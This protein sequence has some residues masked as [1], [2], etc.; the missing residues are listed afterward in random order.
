MS[1]VILAEKPNQAQNYAAAF[2]KQTTKKGYIEV[3]DSTLFQG[4]VYITWGFGHLVQLQEP[5]KYKEEWGKWSLDSLP[6]LPDRYIFEVDP[7]KRVQFNIVKGLLKEASLI[8]VGTDSDREGQNIAMSIIELAGAANKPIKRLW[9]NSLETDEII[10]G[11]KNLRNGEDFLPMYEE[12]RT[13]QISDWAIG[14]NFSRLYTCL[15]QQKGIKD[16]FSVG[17]VQS[18]TLYLIYKRQQEIENFRPEKFYELYADVTAEKGVFTAKYSGRFKSKEEVSSLMQQHNLTSQTSAIISKLDKQLKKQKA[19]KL[20]SLSSLQE[21]ANKLWKYSPSSVL[22]TV[23]N[24][25]ERKIVSYPRT[26]CHFI[27]DAEFNYLLNDLEHYKSL[28]GFEVAYTEPRKGYIE[29]KR[30]QEHYALIPTKKKLNQ[31]EID[32][33]S[34]Q[35]KNIYM[36]I[37]CNTMAMF[38]PDYEYEETNIE[39]DA[40][41]LIFSRTGKVEKNLGWKTLFKSQPKSEK[42]NEENKAALP[43]VKEQENVLAKVH[44]KEG[45]TSPPK[46]FTEGQLIRA[47]KTAGSEVEGNEEKAILKATEGIGTEATRSEILEVLKRKSYINVEKNKVQITP[48]GVI[49]CEAIKG[50]LLASPEMTAKWELYLKKIGNRQGTQKH[51]L[52]SIE[53]FINHLIVE[54]PKSLSSDVIAVN[55]E[56]EMKQDV[57]GVCPSCKKSVVDKGKFYGCEGYSD[58]CKFTLPKTFLKKSISEP[59]IKK[60][61]QIRKSNVIKGFV[62]KNKKKFNAILILDKENQL[63]MEFSNSK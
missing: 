23:Q 59:N 15:I 39:V 42:D 7:S 50:T 49:L 45:V 54:A 3:E 8:V 11:F 24:L 60:L 5:S 38:A 63:K 2:R 26:D 34:S 19:P 51:F 35:E 17:R 47:M 4:K 28:L 31:A 6:V 48:K 32:S 53:K 61:L 62:S 40:N 27:T 13:R 9:I 10:K 58:G 46:P 44:D 22:K 1:T 20:H 33:L 14:I 29:G 21:K 41:G 18:P 52:S 36:E 12:A 57:I 55:I 43:E 56:K 37:V 30:V 16:A 25:Y